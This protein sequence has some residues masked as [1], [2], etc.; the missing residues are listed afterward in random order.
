MENDAEAG[1]SIGELASALYRLLPASGDRSFWSVA[2]S[3][4]LS[5]YWTSPDKAQALR[6]V[7]EGAR[8][9]RTFGEFI[10]ATVLTGIAQCR[11][12][13][14]PVT[15]DELSKIVRATEALGVT[16][17]SLRDPMVLHQ[18]RPKLEGEPIDPPADHAAEE[19]RRRVLR[20]HAELYSDILTGS[21]AERLLKLANVLGGLAM[22]NGARVELPP[23]PQGDSVQATIRL[24][25]QEYALDARWSPE[26]V[27]EGLDALT[28]RV[29]GI[30]G[31]GSDRRGILV[32]VEGVPSDLVLDA[33]QDRWTV[34]LDGHDLTLLLEDRWTLEEALNFKDATQRQTGAHSP[35]PLTPP[36]QA[37]PGSHPRVGARG[38]GEATR[39][40]RTKT[41]RRT[42]WRAGHPPQSHGL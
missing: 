16:I 39:T 3:L 22:A 14:V 28:Q 12:D 33:D 21:A 8:H 18:P 1:R 5:G 29:L 15:Q 35:L 23:K 41:C 37:P 32:A 19:R 38:G 10:E 42:R 4:G 20:A 36:T 2:D 40:Q 13:G 34:L 31:S 27:E 9:E 30:S 6:Q 7:I 26:Q 24:G 17:P 11:E 25:N